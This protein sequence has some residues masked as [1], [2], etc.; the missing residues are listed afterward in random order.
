MNIPQ[1]NQDVTVTN[2][3]DLEQVTIELLENSIS[4]SVKWDQ[5][6]SLE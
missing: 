3:S 5:I 1:A 4:S 6:F 2:L